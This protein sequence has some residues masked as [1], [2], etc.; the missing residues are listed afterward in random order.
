MPRFDIVKNIK[1]ADTFRVNNIISNFD[2]DIEHTK[3]HFKGC[4][5]I[6]GKAWNVGL[7]VGGG[8]AQG[9]ALLHESVLQMLILTISSIK[10]LV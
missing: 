1:L 8:Q 10:L 3:E 7:I 6:E 2:L 5:D 4:I 9:K